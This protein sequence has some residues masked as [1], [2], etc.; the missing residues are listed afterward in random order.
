MQVRV[1]KLRWFI[2]EALISSG[3]QEVRWSAGREGLGTEERPEG[4]EL[5]LRR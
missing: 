3:R 1:R 4:L 2:F 5:L